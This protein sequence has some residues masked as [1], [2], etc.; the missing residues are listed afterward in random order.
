[1]PGLSC[2]AREHSVP[3]AVEE[4]S[5]A[6]VWG[7]A[8][9]PPQVILTS[10]TRSPK[11]RA[12]GSGW[13]LNR[14]GLRGGAGNRGKGAL[15]GRVSL[16]ETALG[17]AELTEI[18]EE[19]AVMSEG[20]GDVAGAVGCESKEDFGTTAVVGLDGIRG[21]RKAR[22]GLGEIGAQVRLAT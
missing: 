22:E 1:M 10:A 16:R 13:H 18:V 12:E 19:S 8:R 14:M 3:A 17:Q 15:V 4:V 7:A 2:P 20:G 21:F 5:D 11:R 6:G 9:R